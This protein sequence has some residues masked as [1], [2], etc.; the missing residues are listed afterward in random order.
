MSDGFWRRRLSADPRAVGRTVVIDSD[1]IHGRRRDASGFPS[2]RPHGAE[3]RRRLESG[4][5]SRRGAGPPQPEPPPPRGLPR[6]TA[7]GRDARTGAGTAR[8]LRRHGEPAVSRRTIPTRNGWRPRVIPLQDDVVG[9]VATPMFVLLCGVGLL[10]LV[11]CVNVAHLVLAR[12]SGRRQEMAIRQALGA[13]VGRLT[14]QL[15]TESA[16]LAAA[17]GALGRAGR[18]VGPARAGRAR[19]GPG[20]AASRTSRSISPPSWSRRRSRSP[21]RCCS[22][23]SRRGT[24]RRVDTFAAA[25][26]GR[27]GAQRGRPRGPRAR[28]PRRR[29]SGDGDGAAHRRGSPRPKRRRAAERACR[30]RD[31]GAGDRAHLAAPAERRQRARLPG[32][33]APRR[34]LPR[35]AP[36]DRG[37]SRRR[38][39][40]HVVADP[41]GWFQSA[42]VRRDRRPRPGRSERP[43]GDAQLPGF[44]Q[45]LRDDGRAGSSAGRPFTDSDRAGSEPVAIVSETAA[46]M[47]WTGRDPIGAAA[48]A[49]VRICRG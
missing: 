4:R 7:A 30:L 25:E 27:T 1:P 24:M 12:S 8:R 22:G 18:V 40:G 43:T 6:A 9:G 48:S 32:S 42:A 19:A 31:R 35:G 33:R 23:S 28:H 17:G 39:R 5:L 36:P 16:V 21:P 37:A 44:A 15:A 13:S 2:S 49:S 14:W 41:D 34:V 20:A 26:G 47:F 3:R 10:L 38:T 46:R 29:R 11:A 45:L